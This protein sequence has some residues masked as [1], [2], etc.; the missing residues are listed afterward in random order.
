LTEALKPLGDLISLKGRTSIITGAASGI[1]R[2]IAYRFAEAGSDLHLLDINAEAL[3]S[4]KKEIAERFSVSTSIHKID[5]SKKEEIDRF[6]EELDDDPDTLVNNAGIYNFRDFLSV[7]EEF[8]E[9]TMK[10]NLYSA[11]WMSQYL[12]RRRGGRGGV[13][14]NIGSIEAILPFAKGLV[15]YDISKAGIIA[16]TRALAREYG[17]LGFRV[18]AV[19]PGGIETPGTERLRREAI[20]KLKVDIIKTGMN[21]MA[22]LPLGRMGKPDE[23]ARVV[24]FLASDLASYVHGALIAVDG[25]FLS[26]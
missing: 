8:L 4:L 26:A 16:L 2:A 5:L 18:N 25:G 24:L 15:H 23:V 1:G 7:D 21:F 6:W 22:R 13:I 11:F 10:V 19:I 12:I 14:I 17:K 9:L 3:K 20:L